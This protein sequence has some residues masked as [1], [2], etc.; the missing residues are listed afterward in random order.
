MIEQMNNKN[1]ELNIRDEV[2]PSMNITF[3]DAITSIS[4]QEAISAID[5]SPKYQK[6]IENPQDAGFFTE[7]ILK[8]KRGDNN[9]YHKEL[10]KILTNRDT[11]INLKDI[12]NLSHDEHTLVARASVEHDNRLLESITSE[13]IKHFIFQKIFESRIK[14]YLNYLWRNNL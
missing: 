14:F 6:C 12:N 11:G 2:I 13:E 7:T 9:Q 8:M 1:I 5:N 4:S 3:D 10:Q